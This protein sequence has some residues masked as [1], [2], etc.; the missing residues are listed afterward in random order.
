VH[1]LIER[2]SKE[3]HQLANDLE[4]GNRLGWRPD[5][6]T[7]MEESLNPTEV[8]TKGDR[9]K[10]T[11]VQTHRRRTSRGLSSTNTKTLLD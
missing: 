9:F 1:R 11:K 7:G 2:K 6:I 5:S 4:Q 3:E 10:R 8:N